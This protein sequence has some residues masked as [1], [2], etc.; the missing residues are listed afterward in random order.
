VIG[1]DKP[2]R[3]RVTLDQ[4]ERS[5]RVDPTDLVEEIDVDDVAPLDVVGPQ[6]DA[7][8]FASGG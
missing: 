1:D 8:W 6:P 2:S 5:E 4:L 7:R 3:F